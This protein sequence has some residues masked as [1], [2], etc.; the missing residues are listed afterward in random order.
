MIKYTKSFLKKLNK[1]SIVGKFFEENKIINILRGEAEE[2]F[3]VNISLGEAYELLKQLQKDGIIITKDERTTG[4]VANCRIEKKFK[5][6]GINIDS[7]NYQNADNVLLK[8]NTKVLQQDIP[9]RLYIRSS[10]LCDKL[11][12][13]EWNALF[14]RYE[15]DSNAKIINRIDDDKS[16]DYAIIETTLFNVLSKGA[17][18]DLKFLASAKIGDKWVDECLH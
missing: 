3:K 4:V 2:H 14:S 11:S 16:H 5:V 9:I 15:N 12:I 10:Y 13:N 7:V 17:I 8:E 1:E 6:Y 18:L